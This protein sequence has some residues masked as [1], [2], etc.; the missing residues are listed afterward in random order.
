MSR[1]KYWCFTSY[2]DEGGLPS[3]LPD[4]MT[5]LIYQREVCPTSAREHYQGYAEF[6]TRVRIAGVKAALGDPGAHCELRRGTGVQAAEYCKKDDSRKEGTVPVELG[7]LTSVTQGARTDLLAVK[8][9]LDS[10]AKEIDIADQEF[11]T[12]AKY[13]RAIERY[14][15]LTHQVRNFKSEVYILTGDTGVGKTRAVA[16]AYPDT[17][18]KPRGKLVL[19]IRR[20]RRRS[21]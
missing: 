8:A 2:V 21:Y 18:W 15:R 13:H 5:Y 11:A 9:L 19:R 10:G 16:D 12:W 4:T 3:V 6:H 14:K 20:S 7:D 17:Y 1:G